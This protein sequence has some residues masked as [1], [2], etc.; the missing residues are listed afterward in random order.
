MPASDATSRFGNRVADYVR[1]RPGYPDEVLGILRREGA[2]PPGAVVADVGS[3]TG[4]SAM[5]FLNAGHTV[6]GVEPNAGMRTAAEELLAGYPT[7]HSVNGSAEATTLPAAS[8]DLAVAGQAFHWFDP[9]KARA[10]FRRVLRPTG[11]VA[12]VWNTR[13]TDTT[14][15]L[16][17]YEQLLRTYGTDYKEVVHTNVDAATLAA[18]FGP[19]GYK[20]F[21]LPSEQQFDLD[22]V[23]GRTRSSSYVPTEGHP[24]YEPLYDGLRRLFETEAVDGMVSF[25]CETEL[26]VGRMDGLSAPV[27]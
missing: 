1:Y 7:F 20:R 11:S 9:P 8:I 15:F 22:G 4:L 16:R 2:L 5:P 18:F 25:E 19:G 23:L 24:N 26:Y 14:P 21:A 27:R 13:K 10:E 12:L 6:Y 3:G 17:G